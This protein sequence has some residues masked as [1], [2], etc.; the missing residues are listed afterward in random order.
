MR[1]LKV[2]GKGEITAT[3]DLCKYSMVVSKKNSDYFS[4]YK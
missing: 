4:C 3:P 2:Q 1:T